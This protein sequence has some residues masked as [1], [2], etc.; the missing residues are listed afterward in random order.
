MRFSYFIKIVEEYKK[1]GDKEDLI[2][3]FRAF[4]TENKGYAEAEEIRKVF[5]GL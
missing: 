4:D 1:P 2:M 5:H 3:S